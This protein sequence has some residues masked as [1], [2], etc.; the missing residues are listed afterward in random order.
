MKPKNKWVNKENAHL[1]YSKWVKQK[2]EEVGNEREPSVTSLWPLRSC[3]MALPDR[4]APWGFEWLRDDLSLSW[5]SNN[6]HCWP[7]LWYTKL[8]FK[9]VQFK[10][11]TEPTSV[12]EFKTAKLCLFQPPCSQTS[13]HWHWCDFLPVYNKR[14]CL[15]YGAIKSIRNI[16][17]GIG[18]SSLQ[19]GI[20]EGNHR[21]KKQW[22]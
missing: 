10:H 5:S 17:S 1:V 13:L 14:K 12:R 16:F 11:S 21:W 3:S 18:K 15:K 7:I 4:N 2:L 9:E 22:E 20:R 6:F 8:F 19:L